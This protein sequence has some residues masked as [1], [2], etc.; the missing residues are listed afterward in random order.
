M[1][2]DEYNQQDV[3]R[4]SLIKLPLCWVIIYRINQDRGIHIN[5]YKM[6]SL[7]Q[8]LLICNQH[9][10]VCLQ[11]KRDMKSKTLD[12]AFGSRQ[13][14]ISFISFWCRTGTGHKATFP[15]FMRRT[16]VPQNTTSR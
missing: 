14:A 3:S 16:G 13:L 10:K 5:P 9:L 6:T 7:D 11:Y 15:G 1:V 8:S 4:N 2:N 12:V